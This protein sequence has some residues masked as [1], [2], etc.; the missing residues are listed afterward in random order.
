LFTSVEAFHRDLRDGRGERT[1]DDGEERPALST[2][3]NGNHK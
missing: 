1:A 3:R 2:Q